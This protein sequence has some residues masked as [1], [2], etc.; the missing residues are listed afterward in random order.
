MV[1]LRVSVGTHSSASSLQQ[2]AQ[3][4]R[5]TQDGMYV[6][7]I[8]SGYSW[9]MSTSSSRV[10]HAL[11]LYTSKKGITEEQAKR[12]NVQSLSCHFHTDLPFFVQLK[13][14]FTQERNVLSSFTY[15]YIIPKPVCCYLVCETQK[16]NFWRIFMRLFS[17]FHPL[18]TTTELKADFRRKEVYFKS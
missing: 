16:E 14:Q 17:I 7:S 2:P 3:R 15:L 9:M 10:L 11:F 8:S 18:M 4:M 13:G 1:T 6:C 12:E 5:T